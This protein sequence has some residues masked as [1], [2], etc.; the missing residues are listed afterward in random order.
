MIGKFHNPISAGGSLP[1]PAVYCPT[2]GYIDPTDPVQVEDAGLI[3]NPILP[4]DGWV[5]LAEFQNNSP[6]T[7]TFD[8]TIAATSG[9][10]A[11]DLGDGTFFIGDKSIS[12]TY[13]TTATR[14]VKLYGKGTCNIT[15][16]DFNTDNIVGVLDLSNDAFKPLSQITAHTNLLMTGVIFPSTSTGTITSVYLYGTGITGVLDLSMF[17]VLGSAVSLQL[18][19]NS[20]LTGVTFAS[21]IS[22]TA[23]ISSLFVY[24]CALSGTLDLSMFNKLGTSASIQLHLNSSLT[25]VT[26]ASSFSA[27]ALGVLDLHNTGIVGT[28]DLSAFSIFTTAGQLQLYNMASL[29]G[30]TF[31][32]SISGTIAQL[33]IYSV[34]ITGT[35]DLSK[36]T[37]FTTTASITIGGDASLTGITFA[38]SISGTIATLA[39]YST[40]ITGTLDL[41]K[42]TTFTNT[43][44]IYLYSNS[45]LTGVIFSASTITGFVRTLQMY[46]NTSLGYVDLTKL[47]T[48]VASLAWRFDGNGWTAAIV[49]QVL[50]NIDAMSVAGFTGRVVNIGGTNTDPDTTSGGYNGSAART[51]LIAKGFTVTIT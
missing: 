38:S 12:H 27:G 49:N 19:S 37:T 16:I 41:S 28:L 18:Q 42:F 3:P 26:F 24:S 36:F 23:T 47:K 30:I 46:S 14:T 21:L 10:Y 4:A 40:G 13:L 20:S 15:T 35:L 44:S 43:A 29:T 22:G 25:G 2:N 45:S 11:W 6:Y 51:S 32:S 50:V 5:L 48:G 39:I 8:P 31:A 7:T 17:T 1:D 9:Q 33:N 34:G